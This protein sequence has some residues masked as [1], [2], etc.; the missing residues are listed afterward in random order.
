[1]HDVWNTWLDG[2]FAFFEMY[3]LSLALVSISNDPITSGIA[4]VLQ[5]LAYANLT[6]GALGFIADLAGLQSM[7]GYYETDPMVKYINP[8][9]TNS[10][11]NLLK[12]KEFV[13]EKQTPMFRLVHATRGLTVSKPQ[14]SA[15]QI[16]AKVLLTDV[17][18]I[19]LENAYA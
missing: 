11:I 12:K 5:A 2:G 15:G 1:M 19:P 3:L 10:G 7:F 17:L 6:Q 4:T 9:E 8:D 13:A 16:A 14:N 18:R